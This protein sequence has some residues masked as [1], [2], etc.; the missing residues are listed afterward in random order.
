MLNYG[1]IKYLF[2]MHKTLSI[3]DKTFID[4]NRKAGK[5]CS[6]ISDESGISLRSVYKWSAIL[7]KTGIVPVIMGRP[8]IG[9]GQTFD[10]G[11]LTRIKNY[12]TDKPFWGAVTIRNE[13]IH[14]N[15]YSPQS[16]PGVRTTGRYLKT[17]SLTQVYEKNR[18]LDMP[19]HSE[20]AKVHECWQMDDKG[21]ET[22]EGIGKVLMI[23][24]KDRVSK[25]YVQSYP[26][27]A[28]NLYSKTT[29]YDYQCA[30]RQAFMEYGLPE[31]I[32]S[33]H[34]SN[35]YENRSRSPMPTPLHLWLLGLGV[36]CEWSRIHR[37]TDQGT[38]ERA[39]QTVHEQV[40][41]K[42]AFR[43]YEAFKN[44]IEER[45]RCL[46]HEIDCATIGKPPLA[47]F[48]TALHSGRFYHIFNEQSLFDLKRIAQY[49]KDKEW[50]R[51]TS[52]KKTVSL[53][54]YV[55]CIPTANTIKAN[56]EIR[57]S[58]DAQ[59]HYLLFH[60]VN[61]LVCELPMK[62]ISHQELAGEILS[63]SF[64]QRQLE[65]PFDLK[66][67]QFNTTLCPL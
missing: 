48:P 23:N 41:R 5:S 17:L 47:A 31:R 54:G 35:F 22:Y 49:L 4:I 66:N 50:F 28:G 10:S 30:L 34:G 18:P 32:Q 21:V 8:H 15:G 40:F 43:N 67:F 36:S 20:V 52:A 3:S 12:R 7:N 37:P 59:T 39:H 26:V 64:F 63:K 60:D 9:P 27:E 1:V 46:N 29:I 51:K 45:R 6:A 65:I 44:R 38:V 33:D 62:G 25:T 24:I 57:I 61:E 53:G 55:Y 13:L 42:T 14:V 16:L 2:T 58:F 19:K 11:I 56:T